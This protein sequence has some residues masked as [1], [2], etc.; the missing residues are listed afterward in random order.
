MAAVILLFDTVTS[1][2]GFDHQQVEDWLR[3]APS[4]PSY[5]EI[6][7][8]HIDA[9]TDV[10]HTAWKLA[11]RKHHPDRH[12]HQGPE[13]E[14]EARDKMVQLNEAWSVLRDPTMRRRYDLLIGIRLASCSRCGSQGRLRLAS[15][16]AAVGICDSCYSRR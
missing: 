6:L 8:V 3:R 10:I 16:G 12:V 13:S 5:Y 1:M 4:S 11:A 7:G 14:M 2:E 9:G 15:G